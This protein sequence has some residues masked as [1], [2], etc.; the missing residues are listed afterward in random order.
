MV[1][2][3]EINSAYHLNW[4]GTTPTV[5]YI[6]VGFDHA[7]GAKDSIP[8]RGIFA[9]GLPDKEL[10]GVGDFEPNTHGSH[11]LK[12]KKKAPPWRRCFPMKTTS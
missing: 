2:R 4:Q 10:T 11:A 12:I 6:E 5:F 1:L 7:G 9:Q 8:A 3:T